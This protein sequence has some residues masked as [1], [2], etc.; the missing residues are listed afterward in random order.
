M[1]TEALLMRYSG[2]EAA[3]TECERPFK[4]RDN[5][6]NFEKFCCVVTDNICEQLELAEYGDIPDR[7]KYHHEDGSDDP[8]LAFADSNVFRSAFRGGQDCVA[9]T[10]RVIG[11]TLA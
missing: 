6:L 8:A 9:P 3:A 10:A 4:C 11:T 1:I 5:H 2:I 7:N